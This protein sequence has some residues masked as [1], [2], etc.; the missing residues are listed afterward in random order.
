MCRIPF[1]LYSFVHLLAQDFTL[2]DF[3]LGKLVFAEPV[4]K[5]NEAASW[6]EK[7]DQLYKSSSQSFRVVI[8]GSKVYTACLFYSHFSVATIP[9]VCDIKYLSFSML[10]C[11]G[12]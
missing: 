7:L 8:H 12:F 2:D 6:R 3:S 1:E 10:L 4:P 11:V 5:D 9:K